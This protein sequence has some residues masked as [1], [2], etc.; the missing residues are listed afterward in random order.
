MVP[1][2]A[3][4]S[5]EAPV[6]SDYWRALFHRWF[7]QYN[8]LYLVSAALV[9]VGLNLVSQGLAHQGSLYGP[10]GVALLAEVY[11][12]V[13]IAGAALLYRRGQERSAVLLALL[14][15][16]YQADLT[17]H[18]ETCAVLGGIGVVPALL[19]LAAFGAKLIGL[20]RAFRL[21]IRPRALLTALLGAVGL[22]VLPY[23]LPHV[24]R[25]A[26]GTLVA[27][28][29]FVL[30]ALAPTRLDDSATPL[31]E[32]TAWGR[33]V[34][35]RSVIATWA[36][37]TVLLLLHIAFWSLEHD[38]AVA[39][40]IPA[41][42]A[43]LVAR[44]RSEGQM[45]AITASSTA[46]VALAAPS[47]L[48]AASALAAITLLVRASSRRRVTSTH[49]RVASNGPDEAPSPYRRA[50][51]EEREETIELLPVPPPE[52]LRLFTGTLAASYL[53]VCAFGWHGDLW[54]NHSPWLDAAFGIVG[55]AMA[56]RFRARLILVLVAGIAVSR[57]KSVGLLP[58][59]QSVI[60]WGVLS[61]ALGFSL[62]L[63]SLALSFLPLRRSDARGPAHREPDA[64]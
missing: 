20:G 14:A 59:P 18:T 15:I 21:R 22:V 48:S 19:W 60:E 29:L 64:S 30:G 54:P 13:L 25:D 63:G 52:R 12:G 62:L 33:L 23:V 58:R 11:A 1:S 2:A 38:I 53:A 31:S 57:L 46:L 9:L 49:D 24:D 55:L 4:Q 39:R 36:I 42:L 7:V 44:Q 40:A 37:W 5:P 34:L 8:P 43:L 47:C 10:L 61:L 16:V 27:L 35:R 56:L 32:Q 45:W 3:P 41:V 50:T 6:Q 28:L 17:L 26:A 51:Q